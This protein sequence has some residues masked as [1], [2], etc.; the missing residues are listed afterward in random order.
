MGVNTKGH[1]V[2]VHKTVDSI[3][4]SKKNISFPFRSGHKF[5]TPK[6]A[7]HC[8]VYYLELF[9]ELLIAWKNIQ[10]KILFASTLIS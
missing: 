8:N 4:E 1:S 6:I 5:E 9:C 2:V 7:V 3:A 10:N